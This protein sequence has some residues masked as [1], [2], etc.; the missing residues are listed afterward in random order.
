MDQTQKIMLEV[1]K[2]FKKICDDNNL[3]YFAAGGTK[4]GAVL[5]GGIIPWDDDIDIVMPI[6]DMYKL[7]KILTEKPVKNIDFFDGLRAD[8]SDIIGIKIFDKNTMFTSNNLISRPEAFTGV[9]IDVFPMVGTPDL[10]EASLNVF[11]LGL[12]LVHDAENAPDL[13]V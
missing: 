9:F 12:V 1:Y 4:L 2:K 10:I 3:R 6:D 13:T 7:I 5:W 11:P 8:Y